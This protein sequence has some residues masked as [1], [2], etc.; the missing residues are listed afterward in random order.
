MGFFLSDWIKPWGDTEM[1]AHRYSME[2]LFCV[3][4][5][6]NVFLDLVKDFRRNGLNEP[7]IKG[8]LTFEDDWEALY[9]YLE[10]LA[11]QLTAILRTEPK[12]LRLSGPIV[13]IGDLLGSLEDLFK[14]KSHFFNGLAVISQTV[15]FLGNYTGSAFPYGFE[16][17]LYLFALKISMPN[18]IYL[19]RGR[20]E[21]RHFNRHLKA[22]LTDKYGPEYGEKIYVLLNQVFDFLPVAAIFEETIL[23]THSGIPKLKDGKRLI[24][25][26]EMYTNPELSDPKE[27]LPPAYEVSGYFFQVEPFSNTFF[28]L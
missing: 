5:A 27:M 6:V 14:L 2:N 22:E 1:S 23:C 15:L 9:Q 18:K 8:L 28:P 25:T 12:I 7:N 20:N 16:C 24:A 26:I 3:N 11:Y 4:S 13:I 19:L 21:L 10:V 17:L